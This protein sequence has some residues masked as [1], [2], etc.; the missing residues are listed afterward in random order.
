MIPRVLVTGASGQLGRDLVAELGRR[1]G[2]E[3]VALDRAQ[4]DLAD[5]PLTLAAFEAARPRWVVHAAAWTDV[6][7][8][9]GDPERAFRAN[10]YAVRNVAEASRRV[11]AHVCLVS[12]DYVFDGRADRPYTEWDATNPESVYGR[13][14]LGGER[15]MDPSW[16]V[17]RTS[18]LFGYHGR[19]MIRTVLGL[20]RRA[21]A[22]GTPLRFVD[23]QE[24]CPTGTEDLAGALLDLTLS[25]APGTFHVTNQGP[26]TWF[27]LAR[28]VLGEAGLDPALVEPV[29]T[30]D[31]VPAR[32]APRPANSVLAPTALRAAGQPLLDDWHAPMARLVR[33][34]LEENA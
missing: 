30:A 13:S 6:D 18:W 2:I 10:A 9:E 34:I 1:P 4:V 25:C 26:T 12:T 7:G 5:R 8:C 3:A 28:D 27:G 33:R 31:L 24:G 23:D 21:E 20:A 32:P 16:T 22:D 15:E 19:N 29:S 17:A 14:K 11:G